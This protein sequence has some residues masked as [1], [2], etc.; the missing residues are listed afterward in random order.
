MTPKKHKTELIVLTI[1]LEKSLL[2]RIGE[3]QDKLGIHSKSGIIRF[4]L[5][6]HLHEE[7]RLL[8]HE[9]RP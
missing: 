6:R 2:E 8:K 1:R 4:I 3:L 7:E 9:R 5:H